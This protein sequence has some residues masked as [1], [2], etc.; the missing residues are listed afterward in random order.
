MDPTRRSELGQQLV[1]AAE[2]GD[3]SGVESLIAQGADMN[4]ADSDPRVSI[5]PLWYDYY[6]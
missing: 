6:Q 5:L 4:H 2:K 3:L 1:Y